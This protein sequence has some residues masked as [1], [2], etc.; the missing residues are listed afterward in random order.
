MRVVKKNDISVYTNQ[1]LNLVGYI[2]RCYPLL[3]Q[4]LGMK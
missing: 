1:G 4:W 3:S 2:D